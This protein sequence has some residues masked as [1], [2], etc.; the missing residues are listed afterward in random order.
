MN[1]FC[2]KGSELARKRDLLLR[3]LRTVVGAMGFVL[4]SGSVDAANI[5]VNGSF[6]TRDFSGWTL[7]GNSGFSGVECPGAPFAGPGDGDCDAFFGPVGANAILS[8]TLVTTPGA[9]YAI[10]FDFQP[11]GGNPSFFSAFFGSQPLTSLTN[12]PASAYQV[13][14]FNRFATAASTSLTFSFRD[15]PGFIKIDS[16]A[17]SAVP[18]PGSIALLSAGMAGLWWRRRKAQ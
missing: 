15:D 5:V 16:V 10:T 2:K 4:A 17:V 12:P 1:A 13:L 18:E 6:E 7:S 9:S 8:Q 11:D 14:T 3:H